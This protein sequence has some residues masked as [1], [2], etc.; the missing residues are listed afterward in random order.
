MR[1]VISGKFIVIQLGGEVVS[2]GQNKMVVNLKERFDE[3]RVRLQHL[4]ELSLLQKRVTETALE[5]TK[6]YVELGKYVY[7]MIREGS[8]Q[9]E[10]LMS[11][12]KPVAD[13]D[14]V[15]YETLKL[16]KQLSTPL[17]NQVRCDCGT[18]LPEEQPFCTAC[19]RKN[20]HYELVN[21]QSTMLCDNCEV[22]ITSSSVYCPCCGIATKAP[23]L[24]RD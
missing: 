17:P 10:E 2:L 12:A 4:Q 5:K 19:G 18:L 7:R 9:N 24:G 15:I 14:K 16:I 8:I 13:Q 11:L 3:K 20:I 22:E 6:T 21:A 1:Q 23:V